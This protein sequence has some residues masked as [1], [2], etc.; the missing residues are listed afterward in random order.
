MSTTSKLDRET[1]DKF[2]LEIQATDRGTPVRTNTTTA[3]IHVTDENDNAPEFNKQRLTGYV[4]ENRV[5]GTSVMTVSA[6][7]KDL[8]E[9]A[10]LRF[11]LNS[12]DAFAINERT[13]EVCVCNFKC[14]DKCKV[15]KNQRHTTNKKP[16]MYKDINKDNQ[17]FGLSNRPSSG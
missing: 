9:N 11:S 6:T 5:K 14:H 17:Y 3:T 2:T 16:N 12:N 4:F 7:D 13:G 15:K 8:G 10:R 1:K